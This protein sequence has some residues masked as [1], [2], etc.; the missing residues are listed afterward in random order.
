MKIEKQEVVVPETESTR[1][2]AD[3]IKEIKTQIVPL[4][5]EPVEAPQPQFEQAK[6]FQELTAAIQRGNEDL[7]KA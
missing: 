7:K 3:L 2:V 4:Q 1:I 6:L 5:K